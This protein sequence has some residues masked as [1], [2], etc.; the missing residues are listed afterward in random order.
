MHV[1]LKVSR[2]TFLIHIGGCMC[3][4][5]CAPAAR[6]SIRRR[7][8]PLC[9][10]LRGHHAT[11]CCFDLA[12]RYKDLDLECALELLCHLHIDESAHSVTSKPHPVT[13]CCDD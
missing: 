3:F 12:V 7:R 6:K 8:R 5:S 9:F 13:Y 1:D 2:R 4:V 10:P 11:K